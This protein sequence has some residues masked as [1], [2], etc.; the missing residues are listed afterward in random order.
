MQIAY[1]RVVFTS[2]SLDPPFGVCGCGDVGVLGLWGV[3]G[4]GFVRVREVLAGFGR[5]VGVFGRV[6]S[7]WGRA[8]PVGDVLL[9]VCLVGS[10]PGL[11][12]LR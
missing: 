2:L 4:G 6:W 3:A 12:E 11:A 8:E 10:G 9:M 7:A 1:S 5:F